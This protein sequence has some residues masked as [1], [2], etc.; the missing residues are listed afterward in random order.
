MTLTMAPRSM[1][2]RVTR[3]VCRAAAVRKALIK[4]ISKARSGPD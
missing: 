2:R 4:R 1:E 3:T